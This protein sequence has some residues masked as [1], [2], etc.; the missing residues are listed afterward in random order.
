MEVLMQEVLKDVS[1]TSLNLLL[2]LLVIFIL[3][4][5]GKLLVSKLSELTDQVKLTNGNVIMLKTWKDEHDKQDTER[6]Q[7][8]TD[9]LRALQDKAQKRRAR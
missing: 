1:L 9:Q 6:H 7:E 2:T 8:V 3:W 5:G 4:K